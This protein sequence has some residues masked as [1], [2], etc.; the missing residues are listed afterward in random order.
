MSQQ[1]RV[2]RCYKC[3]MFQ[4]DQVKKAIKW[5]CKICHEKQSTKKI[6]GLGSGKDCRSIVQKLNL[7][8]GFSE[9]K[10]RNADTCFEPDIDILT[11]N[12][13]RT[14]TTDETSNVIESVSFKRNIWAK[15]LEPDEEETAFQKLDLALI[16]SEEQ[17]LQNAIYTADSDEYFSQFNGKKRRRSDNSIDK[18]NL[19]KKLNHQTDEKLQSESHFEAPQMSEKDSATTTDTSNIS[20]SSKWFK[21]ID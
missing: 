19:T 5:N 11:S 18:I 8:K 16:K 14:Q 6:Y 21:Y 7:E 17:P 12:A 3:N 9:E 2:V 20:Q 15:Y 1:F 4:V 10:I 13:T